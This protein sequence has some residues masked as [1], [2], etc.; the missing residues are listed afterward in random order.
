MTKLENEDKKQKRA[1]EMLARQELFNE[2]FDEEIKAA[3]ELLNDEYFVANLSGRVRIVNK[4]NPVEQTP[5]KDF[6]QFMSNLKI[7]KKI[8]K[9]NGDDSIEV[10]PAMYWF[11]DANTK[12]FRGFT[13]DPSQPYGEVVDKFG[14]PAWNTFKGFTNKGIKNGKSRGWRSHIYYNICK[15]NKDH[16]NYVMDVLA[17]I[18]QHPEN[19]H[20]KILAMRGDPGAGKGIMIEAIQY[21]LG[22]YYAQ[23]SLSDL[24]EGGFNG[25][26]FQKLLAVADESLFSGNRGVISGLKRLSG[27]LTLTIHHKG[28]EKFV[29]NNYV[30]ILLSTNDEWVAPKEKGDRR[31]VVWTVGSKHKDDDRYFGKIMDDMKNGGYEDLLHHL[32]NRKITSNFNG[33]V[34]IFDKETADEQ[35]IM[36]LESINPT[37][38]WLYQCQEG[39][40]DTAENFVKLGG[41]HK[42]IL[43]YG[44]FKKW[45]QEN[46]IYKEVSNTM[47]GIIIKKYIRHGQSHSGDRFYDF[48]TIIKRVEL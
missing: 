24:E 32:L 36:T 26:L 29:T 43:V 13:F 9:P 21:L 31:Y 11:E 17:D 3:K 10:N 18:F 25:N 39:E 5:Y 37:L 42:P 38:L 7:Y 48:S 27:N 40:V 15:R 46:N 45:C 33:P 2:E 22:E 35:R 14:Y 30:R 16:Y 34:P 6:I 44:C 41:K 19:K 12:R 47:F 8:A 28:R 20:P 1:A 4:H 23:L